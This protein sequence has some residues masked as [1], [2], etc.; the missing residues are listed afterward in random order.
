MNPKRRSFMHQLTLSYLVLSILPI[1]LILAAVFINTVG[2]SQRASQ[3]K[4]DSTVLLISSQV[5]AL[6]DNMSFTSINLISSTEVMKSAKGLQYPNNTPLKEQGYYSK[7]K[8]EFCTYAIVDSPYN[9]TFFTQDGHYITSENYNGAYNYRYRLPDEELS[10]MDWIERV[11]NNYGQ[12]ILLPVQKNAMPLS[13]QTALTLVRA[14]RDPGKNVGYLGVQVDKEQ[15]DN[16]FSIGTQAGA[17]VLMLWED[18]TV[19]YSSENFPLAKFQGTDIASGLKNL[20]KEY[21]VS[22]SQNEKN[23]VTM[24]LVRSRREVVEAVA[25]SVMVLG[26]EAA[27]LLLLTV[28]IIFRYA[29]RLTRPIR[30]LTQQMREI[31]INNLESRKLLPGESH[32]YEE[33][34]YLYNGYSEMRERLNVMLNNEIASKTLQMQE[35]LNSL[36]SQINPHFLYNT[37]NVIGI[38]GTESG[39]REIYDACLKLSSLLRYSIADKNKG[40]STIRK[41]MENTQAYLELM[42]LRFEHRLAY[43]IFCEEEME[44]VRV[45]RLILQPF[46]E[47]V[48]E[49]A[50]SA[51]H[52]SVHVMIKGYCRGERWYLEIQ[53][54]GRGM[55]E[56]AVR[57]LNEEIREC[58]SRVALSEA[59]ENS[60]GIGV[61]NTILRLF[62]FFGDDFTYSISKGDQDGINV[63][64]SAE[65]RE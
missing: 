55:D 59:G 38:M 30:V 45:P 19:I 5:N 2:N 1:M 15:L 51:E 26:M 43:E 3:E 36:Q 22:E 61:Q 58:C 11:R 18:S 35:R 10:G 50:Y 9:V 7:L 16:I 28:A 20:S 65:R 24:V 47:N 29:D 17:Q 37:L 56:A 49:H 4:L 14:V 32:R 23:D 13:K 6:V 25:G 21:L 12:S 39:N 44:E 52:I 53:D 60:Y 8:M 33:I 54:D 31:T 41:E 63:V 40:N 62:L 64:L 34:E 27:L 42:K 57:R 48:F 46:V